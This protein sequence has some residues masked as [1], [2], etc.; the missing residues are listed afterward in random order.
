M[1][2]IDPRTTPVDDLAR[3]Q[4]RQFRIT[5]TSRGEAI[6]AFCLSCVGTALEVR[7]CECAACPLYPFRLGTD[8]FRDVREMSD[9][10]RQELV[11]RMV[12]ARQARV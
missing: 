3:H 9:E 2:T 7:L 11:E 5:R 12:R 8:P 10:Q 6:R 4:V 1:T